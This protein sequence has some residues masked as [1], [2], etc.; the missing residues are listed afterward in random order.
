M[1][2]AVFGTGGVGG[3][4]GGQLARAG[5][6][7]VFIARGEHLQAMRTKGL[8]I[9]DNED[10]FVMH[11]IQATDDPQQIGVVDAILVGVKAWQVED[12]ALAMRPMIGEDTFVVPLQNGMDAPMQL[13]SVLGQ[14]HVLG[15]LCGTV[16]YIVGPG[17]IHGG[18]GHVTFGE[19]DNR[20]S[21]R[22]KRLLE[23]FERAGINAKIATDIHV[24]LW[25][26][27]VMITAWS[28]IG[29]VTRAPS[30]VWGRIPETR[31]MYDSVVDE[32][33]AVAKGHGITIPEDDIQHTLTL[34]DRLSPNTTASMQR[35]IMD[36]RPSELEYQN[37]TVV[38]LGR[39]VGVPTPLHA[40]IYHSLLPL[41]QRA[42]GEIE[43]PS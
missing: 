21:E 19:L 9:D 29:A 17:H 18:G 4:F 42:R 41:E 3:N 39:K 20:I 28:G 11:P 33:L 27:L 25:S 5:E 10:S 36:G 1:R 34:P 16:S 38:R 6:D 13:A 14:Q 40:F 2:I 26:K 8:R 7:V 43:F 35:D 23:V 37:G 24:A 12:A 32:T 30:G 22:T 15:G 31:Q